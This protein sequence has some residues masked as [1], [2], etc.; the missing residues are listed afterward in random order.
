MMAFFRYDIKHLF[1]RER[2]MFNREYITGMYRPISFF[3]GRNIAE[4]PLQIIFV[5]IMG[6]IA[7]WMFGLQSDA[8]KYFHF[9]VIFQSLG[10]SVSGFMLVLSA[11]SKSQE[12]ASILTSVSILTCMLFDGNWVSLDKVPVYC[13]WIEYISCMSW[14]SQAIIANEYGASP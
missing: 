6:T 3:V 12:Q 13:R 8:E 5:W 4:I 10:I 2:T 11:L 7:Y 1:L 9:M 14:A